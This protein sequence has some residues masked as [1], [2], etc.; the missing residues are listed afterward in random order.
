MD[1]AKELLKIAIVV[2]SND[3]PWTY[4]ST[5]S[6]G[7]QIKTPTCDIQLLSTDLLCKIADN[8]LGQDKP[9]CDYWYNFYLV[10]KEFHGMIDD[11]YIVCV[12]NTDTTQ[13]EVIINIDSPFVALRNVIDHQLMDIW[14]VHLGMLFEDA[15]K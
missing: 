1:L 6:W 11:C 12:I 2:D 8:K 7:H 9:P 14:G 13:R 4:M 10:V 3:Y 15:K 5:P